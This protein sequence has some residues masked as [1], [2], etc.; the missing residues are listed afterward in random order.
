MN[1]NDKEQTIDLTPYQEILPMASAKDVLTNT[2]VDLGKELTLG[3][4]GIL[5]LE[6]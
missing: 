4:R 1:G 5:V 2:K 3:S 6:F